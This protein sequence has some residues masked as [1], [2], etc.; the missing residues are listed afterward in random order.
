MFLSRGNAVAI[1]K[2]IFIFK[3]VF[4]YHYHRNYI[5]N[6]FNHFTQMKWKIIPNKFNFVRNNKLFFAK[7]YT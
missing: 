5:L 2:K 7:S 4:N 3:L 1:I 6:N